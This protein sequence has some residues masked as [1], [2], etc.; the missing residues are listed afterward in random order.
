MDCPNTPW[1]DA[2]A[3]AEKML[4]LVEYQHGEGDFIT[5]QRFRLLRLLE[6]ATKE[7]PEMRRVAT[8]SQGTVAG[9]L[10]G[11]ALAGGANTRKT[12][13]ELLARTFIKAM[14]D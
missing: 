2:E 11:C 3:D 14:E 8:Q 6:I 7:F 5:P 9:A 4:A 13:I 1:Q 12:C 10:L